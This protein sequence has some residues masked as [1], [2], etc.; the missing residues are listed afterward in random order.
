MDKSRTDT[1]ELVPLIPLNVS[2]EERALL[3]WDSA[4]FLKQVR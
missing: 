2:G 4:R 3:G 1:S